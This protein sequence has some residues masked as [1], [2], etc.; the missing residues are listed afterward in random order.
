MSFGYLREIKII[1]ERDFKSMRVALMCGEIHFSLAIQNK[2][3]AISERNASRKET[4]LFAD[5]RINILEAFSAKP[6][7]V[8]THIYT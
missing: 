7:C 5:Y 6:T 8:H 2:H 3:T 1:A 4:Q